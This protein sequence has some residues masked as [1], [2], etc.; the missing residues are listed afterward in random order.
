MKER[1]ERER[2]YLFSPYAVSVTR[3]EVEGLILAPMLE[4]AVRN[5]VRKNELLNVRVAL[6]KNG[7]AYYETQIFD[8]NPNEIVKI[9]QNV[10][11][12]DLVKEQEKIAFDLDH[13]ELVR[14]FFLK[15]E[16]KQ[17]FVVIA[18][19]LLGDG[20]SIAF[21]IE[22]ILYSLSD[23]KVAAKPYRKPVRANQT[24]KLSF[25]R[26]LQENKIRS[27]WQ[28]EGA[29]FSQEEYYKLYADFWQKN[30]SYIQYETFY[31]DVLLRI[32]AFA[33][34]EGVSIGAAVL[35]AFAKASREL[36]HVQTQES[37][38]ERISK[39]NEQ[40]DVKELQKQL[41]PENI[42]LEISSNR[43]YKGI[44]DY[45]VHKRLSFLYEEEQSFAAN[46][47]RLDDMLK[48]AESTE[49]FEVISRFPKS[50]T[51]SIHFQEAG[52]YM[53]PD[54]E[55]LMKELGFGTS[56]PGMGVTN[57]AKVPIPVKYRSHTLKN[58]VYVP[59]MHTGARRTLGI[60]IFGNVMNI[61]LH[62]KQ[63]AYLTNAKIFFQ[64][65]IEILRKL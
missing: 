46:A 15:N 60:T 42:F 14:F 57:L 29:V 63:D 45:A 33:K 44:G 39:A 53:S 26:K 18:H 3:V 25:M 24:P 64:K 32:A 37:T 51:D 61:S 50:F 38:D 11:W 23:M 21:L 41:S 20:A 55:W 5:A 27:Q 7:E 54:T 58:Y 31:G 19:R 49:E 43:E 56:T 62:V 16:E 40:A 34:R 4:D 6:S 13:G 9:Y 22:D 2:L 52:L 17:E 10:Y 35:T 12:K 48:Q 30:T 1:L 8:S 65:G 59:P 36:R 47:K 28:K